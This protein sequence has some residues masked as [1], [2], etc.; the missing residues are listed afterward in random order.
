MLTLG[1]KDTLVLMRPLAIL[2][3]LYRANCT[4]P[5]SCHRLAA[6]LKALTA[7]QSLGLATSRLS[8]LCQ[9]QVGRE[10]ESR[11]QCVKYPSHRA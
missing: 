11:L 10:A 7:A 2:Q 6:T 3:T 4:Q 8:H 9:F 5:M 1:G